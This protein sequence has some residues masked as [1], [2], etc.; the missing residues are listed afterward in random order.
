[1]RAVE[2]IE[3]GLFVVLND[4]AVDGLMLV[5]ITVVDIVR[6]EGLVVDV[7]VDIGGLLVVVVEFVMPPDDG[8]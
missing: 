4:D 8:L 1:M 3:D 2:A 6:V 7:M 5:D